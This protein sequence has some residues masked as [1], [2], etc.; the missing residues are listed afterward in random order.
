MDTG[1]RENLSSI[2]GKV[3]TTADGLVGTAKDTVGGW[4]SEA[5][6]S[7]SGFFS[8]KIGSNTFDLNDPE[9]FKCTAG[10]VVASIPIEN[11]INSANEWVGEFNYGWSELDIPRYWW[12]SWFVF[13]NHQ[14]VL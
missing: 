3:T 10:G 8:E 1:I 14:R 9:N 13:S 11:I 12:S 6:D 5:K 4:A 7:V 2:M